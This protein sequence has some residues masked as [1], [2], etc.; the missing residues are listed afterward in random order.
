MDELIVSAGIALFGI[1]I[2]IF[3]TDYRKGTRK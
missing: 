1:I 3:L 2:V